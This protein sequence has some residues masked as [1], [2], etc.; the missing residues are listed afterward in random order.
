M[1]ER[2]LVL[3][4]KEGNENAFT[5][6]YQTYWAKVYNFSRLYL[7]S[8]SEIEEVVQDV[9][10]KVWEARIFIKENENFKGFL[11][12]ITRNII[13]NQFR[14]SFNESA[15]KLAVLKSS[16][17]TYGIEEE[18]EAS[19][20]QSYINKLIEELPP[21]QRDVFQM[22]RDQHLSYKE[23]AQQLDITEK[24]VERHINEALKFLRKN[25]YFF[26]LFLSI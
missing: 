10:V 13:F 15:Y 23:I 11:F 18:M 1:D 2:T 17:E 5:T 16:S 12:I 22:S 7:T 14:K 20:L 3:Q 25:V 24:T 9:F 4:L 19:D 8:S 26:S 6:L 21:R